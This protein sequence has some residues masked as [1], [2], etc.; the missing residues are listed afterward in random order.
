MPDSSLLLELF[1]AAAEGQPA[2][3]PPLEAGQA[4]ASLGLDPEV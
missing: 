2:Q 4:G 3:P 1:Y